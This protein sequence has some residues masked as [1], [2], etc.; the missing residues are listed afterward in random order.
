MGAQRDPRLDLLKA[1][2]ITLVVLGHLIT[3]A[4]GDP[5]S[6]PWPLAS[7]FSVLAILDVPL[8]VFVSGYLA[9]PTAGAS[10]LKRRALQ[11]LVPYFSW[12]ALRWLL[13]YRTDVLGWLRSSVLWGNETNALWFLY[14]LFVVSALYALVCRWRPAMI[15]LAVACVGALAV[16]VPL[17]SLRYVAMLFPV[18]VVGRL[19]GERRFEPGAWVLAVTAALLVAMWSR[20]G[21]NLLFS[22]PGWAA[23]GIADGGWGGAAL[24]V[25]ATV[26]RIALMLALC[27][28]A[29]Y[30]ARG[31]TRGAWLGALTLGIYAVHPI[32]VPQLARGGGLAGLVGGFAIT[33]VAAT[34]ATLLLARWPWTSFL[35]LGNG[36][37]PRSTRG[38]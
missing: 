19:V 6:A 25:T 1:V 14:A 10:W 20:P 31:A 11:L 26:L 32:V 29:L 37:L 24:A 13:Y 18:F 33:M 28:S 8:F 16:A 36:V 7:V 38:R 5:V 15:G 4:F 23:T 2:A 30:L 27:G 35:L 3:A 12:I 22:W 17:F 34:G 9:S 21:A